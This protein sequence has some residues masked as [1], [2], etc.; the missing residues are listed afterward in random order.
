LIHSDVAGTE[1]ISA[2]QRDA[3]QWCCRRV[4]SP[5]PFLFI[6]LLAFAG[7]AMA[8]SAFSDRL[9]FGRSI[10]GGG[11]VS[12]AQWNAFVTEMIVPRFPEGFS[13]WRG[14][15]HWKGDDGASVSEQT[16]VLEV[17]HGTD[18]TVD[19]KLEEIAR[20]YRQRF[21]QDAV[22]RIRTPAEQTFSR[23]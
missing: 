14:A 10:P 8:P 2:L 21:N 22:M 7:C 19:A 4:V 15:G 9:F 13:V 5:R 16:C 23:R 1:R 17:V 3:T 12:E 18:P 20:A 11:E 6:V